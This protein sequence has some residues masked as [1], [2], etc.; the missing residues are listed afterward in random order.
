MHQGAAQQRDLT[1]DGAATQGSAGDAAQLARVEGHIHALLGGDVEGSVLPPMARPCFTGGGKRMRAWLALRACD[2]LRVPDVCAEPWAAACELMHN[3]TLVHDDL[4]D[5]D[6]TRRGRPALW[7]AHGAAQAINV[8]DWLFMLAFRALGSLPAEAQHHAG[9]ALTQALAAGMAEVIEGQGIECA[10]RAYFAAVA[11]FPYEAMVRGKTAA[12]FALPVCGAALLAG[13]DAR[14]ARTLAAPFAE[15]GVLFQQQDDV[16]D[17]W[18]DKGRELR[19]ADFYEGK[20]SAIVVTHLRRVPADASWLLP[21]LAAPRDATDAGQV[22]R[23][24]DTFVQSGSRAALLADMQ[25]RGERARNLADPA[26]LPVL[27]GLLA[28]IWAPIA[29]LRPTPSG[30]PSASD[31][32]GTSIGPN[33]PSADRDGAHARELR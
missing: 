33:V 20:L 30:R 15:L 25:K 2:A 14:A 1:R 7:V 9:F 18:G 31:A 4:Q 10:S 11:S 3:A 24:I 32:T 27:D 19:G 5:G 22:R 26:L 29:P 8:G 13:Y 6:T 23:A 17:L 16:L 21:L 12:L 28:R